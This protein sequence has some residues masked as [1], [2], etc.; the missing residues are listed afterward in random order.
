[1]TQALGIW[2]GD[3]GGSRKVPRG[4]LWTPSVVV[5]CLVDHLGPFLT[6][7]IISGLFS[8]S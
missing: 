8:G 5:S 1:M 3:S 4:P 2:C 7:F 6:S